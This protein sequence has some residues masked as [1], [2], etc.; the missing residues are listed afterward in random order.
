MTDK[1][2]MFRAKKFHTGI[3]EEDETEYIE[4]YYVQI[5]H[6]GKIYDSMATGNLVRSEQGELHY[7]DCFIWPN[8]L[9]YL[10]GNQ[11]NNQ[12]TNQSTAGQQSGEGCEWRKWNKEDQ[13]DEETTTWECECTATESHHGEGSPFDYG[14]K[15]CYNCGK[16]IT[17]INIDG[18]RITRAE[19]DS[20]KLL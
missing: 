7:E 2:G 15:Y 9:E 18:K 10:G 14:R 4:G 11:V 5:K 6:N 13:W 12:S 17:A 16:P 1:T 20:G 19:Y 3:L 8:T